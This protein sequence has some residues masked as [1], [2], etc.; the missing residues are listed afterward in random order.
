MSTKWLEE[1]KN[2]LSLLITGYIRYCNVEGV[3]KVTLQEK[4]KDIQRIVFKGT[5]LQHVF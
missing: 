1:C 4:K 5:V 3:P 2:V